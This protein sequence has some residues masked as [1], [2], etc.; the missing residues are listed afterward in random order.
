MFKNALIYIAI[1]IALTF[2]CYENPLFVVALIFIG[3]IVGIFLFFRSASKFTDLETVSWHYMGIVVGGLLQFNPIFTEQHSSLISQFKSAFTNYSD[4]DE[5]VN[6]AAGQRISVDEEVDYSKLT[7]YLSLTKRR[8]F[9]MLLFKLA[10][11]DDGI[12]NDEWAYI[13][14]VMGKLKLNGR[15]VEYMHRRFGPLRTEY[16]YQQTENEQQGESAPNATPLVDC[17]AALGLT[18]DSTKEQVQSAYRN[19]AMQYHPDLPKNADTHDYCVRKMA[20][21]NVAYAKIME[22]YANR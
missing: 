7:E 18:S 16:D 22:L 5:C 15:T 17:F 9:V 1:V 8:D 21:V 10:A 11:E 13:H 2:I 12:K 20:E 6:K 4:F 14:D 3:I 19:L